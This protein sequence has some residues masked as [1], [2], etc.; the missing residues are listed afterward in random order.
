MLTTVDQNKENESPI[1]WASVSFHSSVY[2]L[3]CMRI[4]CYSMYSITLYFSIPCTFISGFSLK[5]D[6]NNR[7]NTWVSLYFQ[8]LFGVVR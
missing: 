3:H 6:C 2:E 7:G 1:F 5:F 8:L 4:L